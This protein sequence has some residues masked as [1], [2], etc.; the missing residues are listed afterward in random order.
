M[1]S[2]SGSQPNS[3]ARRRRT[4]LDVRLE[5]L[6][7][8]VHGRL[9]RDVEVALQRLV[10]DA[11]AGAHAAVVQ[12]DDRAVEREGLL[13]LAPEVSSCG[14]VGAHLVMLGAIWTCTS[15]QGFFSTGAAPAG[16]LRL[17][18]QP[19]A[20]RRALCLALTGPG[21]ISSTTAAPT[22][23]ALAAGRARLRAGKVCPPPRHGPHGR[24]ILITGGKR[25]GAA[26]AARPRAPRHGR[27]AR[28]QHL[29]R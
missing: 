17:R 15:A 7:H 23:R 16:R 8:V 6:P 24:S 5:D 21:A 27:R 13:D 26:V 20:D 19:R 14:E 9:V 28:V 10:D 2:S 4:L 29:G 12:V 11:R 3:A 18:V 25:I 22:P 1:A